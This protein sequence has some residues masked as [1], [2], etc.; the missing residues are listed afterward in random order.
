MCIKQNPHDKTLVEFMLRDSCSSTLLEVL[1]QLNH[2]LDGASKP[3]VYFDKSE[4]RVTNYFDPISYEVAFHH[5]AE[6]ARSLLKDLTDEPVE[7]SRLKR[8]Q[9][10]SGAS[11]MS[12][13]R[14]RYVVRTDVLAGYEAELERW[15]DE[16]HMAALAAVPGTVRAQ[17]LI[18]LDQGPRYYA[19]YDLVSEEVLQSPEWSAARGTNWSNRIRPFFRNTRRIVSRSVTEISGTSETNFNPNQV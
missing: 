11:S 15:Y 13:A 8:L 14:F 18:S 2:S 1:G 7:I 6:L 9:I 3:D 17:R 10:H 16:E 19:C 5:F 4:S 12:S